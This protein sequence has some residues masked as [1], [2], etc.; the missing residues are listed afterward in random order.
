MIT[1]IA[2]PAVDIA[3]AKRSPDK[4]SYGYNDDVTYT[5]ETGFLSS[6][7]T[8]MTRTCTDSGWSGR[9]PECIGMVKCSL[10]PGL[11]LTGQFSYL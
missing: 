3:N 1:A 9:D 11:E 8:S 2:C 5:C 6:D 4:D 7:L 10:V